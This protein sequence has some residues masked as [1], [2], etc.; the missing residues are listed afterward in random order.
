MTIQFQSLNRSVKPLLTIHLDPRPSTLDLTRIIIHLSTLK[1][2][3]TH[4]FC[5][6][7]KNFMHWH[8]SYISIYSI[9]IQGLHG[10]RC[11]IVCRRKQK[12]PFRSFILLPFDWTTNQSRFKTRPERIRNLQILDEIDHAGL[13]EMRRE[14]MKIQTKS[15]V[16]ISQLKEIW[17]ILYSRAFTNSFFLWISLIFWNSLHLQYNE[18]IRKNPGIHSSYRNFR[19]NGKI[20]VKNK[21]FEIPWNKP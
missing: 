21:D 13:D 16:R 4:I 10:K 5:D 9:L 15:F 2:Q 14:Q 12:I 18:W 6:S 17:L 19:K 3:P 20:Y 7:A 8:S 1:N 11:P